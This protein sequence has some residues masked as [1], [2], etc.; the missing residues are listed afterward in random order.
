MYEVKKEISLN[1][2]VQNYTN[3]QKYVSNSEVIPVVKADAYGHGAVEVAQ[4][5]RNFVKSYFAVAFT[6]EAVEL[7]NH[8]INND[9]LVLSRCGFGD[10]ESLYDFNLT[11]VVYDFHILSSIIDFAKSKRYRFPIHLKFNTGMNRLG[12]D[13]SDLGRIIELY[14]KNRDYIDIVGIMSHFS[15]SESSEDLT[16]KQIDKFEDIIKDLH[17]YN[18]EIKYHHISNS[19]GVLNYKNAHYNAVRVGIS[20]YGYYPKKIENNPLNIKPA[21]SIKS[22]IISKHEVKKG[23]G[24][25]YG[26]SFVAQRN[27]H[28]AI[29]AFGY[30]DGLFRLMSNKFSVIVNDKLCKSVGTICMDMFAIDISDIE[31]KVGDEVIIMGESNTHKIDADDLALFSKTINYEILTNIGKSLRVRRVYV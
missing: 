13:K 4:S 26:P 27:M 3:I 19:G 21:M 23:E 29:V 16:I 5:L 2:I 9:I 10:I 15:S 17:S 31:A 22:F 28:V 11:P 18:I 20:L 30:A 7:R 6:Q 8:G 1:T 14:N 24:I 12:F 25:S